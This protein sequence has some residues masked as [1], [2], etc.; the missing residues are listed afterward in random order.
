M[1]VRAVLCHVSYVVNGVY[2]VAHGKVET[3]DPSHRGEG[4]IITGTLVVNKVRE[5]HFDRG[6]RAASIA[7]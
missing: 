5:L 4:C 2:G 1:H 3:Q 6:A 7:H